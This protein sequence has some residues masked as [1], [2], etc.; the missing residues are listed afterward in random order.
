LKKIFWEI[1]LVLAEVIL[2]V[3]AIFIATVPGYESNNSKRVLLEMQ[4]K[5]E[6]RLKERSLTQRQIYPDYA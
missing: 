4:A 6:N 3:G 1:T 5:V 2:Y